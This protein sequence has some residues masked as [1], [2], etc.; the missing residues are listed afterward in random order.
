MCARE[1]RRVVQPVADHQDILAGGRQF[2]DTGCLVLWQ[3]LGHPFGD[4]KP[5]CKCLNCRG[6]VTRHEHHVKSLVFQT[7]HEV[8]GPFTD[9]INIAEWLRRRVPDAQPCAGFAAVS[10]LHPIGATKFDGLAHPHALCAMSGNLCD[11]DN[12]LRVYANLANC[13]GQRHR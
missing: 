13:S 6:C 5:R 2:R 7:T 12:L 4:A 3:R 1:R 10:A 8:C 11:I 9:L